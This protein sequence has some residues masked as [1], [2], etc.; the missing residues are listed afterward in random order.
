MDTYQRGNTTRGGTVNNFAEEGNLGVLAY[1]IKCK[2]ENEAKR[3]ALRFGGKA[4]S[5]MFV[6]S[7]GEK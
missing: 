1:M 2:W 5:R 3:G 4:S 7:V 6:G